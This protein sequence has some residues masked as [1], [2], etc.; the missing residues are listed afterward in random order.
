MKAGALKDKPFSYV[1]S[2]D[3]QIRI[4]CSG[5]LAKTIR[6]NAA[7]KFHLKVESV[8]SQAAQLLMAK[9]TGQFKFGNER[10]TR[11]TD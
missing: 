8:D 2:K 6:G 11:K 4:Y 5:N 1:K 3:G 9:E 10:L 7:S